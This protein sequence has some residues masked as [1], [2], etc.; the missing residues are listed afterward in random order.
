LN[1]APSVG[2]AWDPL[3]RGKTV[4]RAGYAIAYDRVFDTI[5]DLRSNSLQLVNCF[6]FAGCPLNFLVPT[7]DML[8]VLN[9]D[10]VLPSP[11]T[12]VHLDENL[13][14]PYAQNWYAGL[15]QTVTP[16]FLIEFGHAGSVGTKLISRDVI[17]RF[18]EGVEQPNSQ[19]DQITSLSNAGS[20]SYMA[21]EVG[22]RRR[23]SRGLQYQ[24]SYTWSHAIDNQSDV[25]EGVPTDPRTREFALATFTRAFDARVDRGNANFDQRHNLVFNVIWDIPTPNFGAQW[26][27]QIL[28]GWT[29][30]LIGAH[31]TG[32]PVT[33]IG[34]N[35]I[36]STTGLANNRVDLVGSPYLSA[37]PPVPGGVQFLDPSAFA[38]AESGVGNLG[39]GAIE[40]PGSWNYDFALLR[41]VAL[42]EAIGLQFRTEFYN[43]FNH[44]NLS[45]PV[46]LFGDPDFGKAYYGLNRTHSRFGDLPL[47]NPARRVQFGLRLS[48]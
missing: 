25:F 18:I 5:K 48:F 45:R 9:Q 6:P 27:R 46:S 41:S 39:R 8:P 30:S 13:R 32:F 24:V 4:L 34:N 44:A 7:E 29:V 11:Y 2:I 36:D 40:G 43:V 14:T 15:Q 21:L 12:V 37:A 47:E 16:N 3:G 1:F 31:R 33:V 10:S 17:N 22:L 35:G 23:F 20:S 42:T 26:P 19:V 28:G 38:V